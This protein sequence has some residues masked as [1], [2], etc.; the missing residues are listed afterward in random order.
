MPKRPTKSGN[1]SFSVS[2]RDFLTTVGVGAQATGLVTPAPRA[3]EAAVLGP[4]AV[5]LRSTAAE[6]AL[7]GKRLD[8]AAAEAAAHPLS[9]NGYKLELL[10]VLVRWNLK[11]LA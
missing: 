9:D 2:R 3:A 4:D 10:K 5:P 11:S 7:I 8:E 1:A 6:Q